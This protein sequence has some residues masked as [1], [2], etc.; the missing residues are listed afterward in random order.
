M[1]DDSVIAEFQ[2]ITGCDVERA[3]FYI[4][5]ANGQLELAISSF[6]EN[7]GGADD[8]VPPEAAA[9][10]GAGPAA[11]AASPP[12]APAAAQPPPSLGAAAAAAAGRGGVINFPDDDSDESEGEEGQAFYAGGS[13]HSGNVILGPG[14]KKDIVGKL[15]KKA[16]ESG[17]EEVRPGEQGTSSGFKAFQGGGFKLGS[18]EAPSQF[19]GKP[20]G[21]AGKAAEPRS[22]VLKM[23]QEGFSLDDGDL[24]RYDDP[25]NREFLAN[26]M[27]GSIPTEL[28]RE[29]QGG[30]VHVDMEDHR[31]E[32]FVKPKRKIKPFEG[33]GQTLGSIAPQVVSA[34]SGGG[35]SADPAQAE[36]QA[37]SQAGVDESKP[38]TNIQVRLADGSR[39]IVKLNHEQTVGTLRQYICT[40]RPQYGTTPF[41]LNTTFPNKELTDDSQT[42][43]AAGLLGAAVLQRLK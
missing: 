20:G 28:I 17:A 43:K 19:V 3:K 39:L 22:F 8:D 34:P 12:A 2:A 36:T 35:A 5:S 15:F 31:N 32:E 42:L 40:A 6:Y 4:E 18:D 38:T 29:A 1:A 24:R 30:E 7:G 23:W 13:T 21:S 9:G 26:I 16:R 10:G 37:K 14:K 25:A 33:S 41:N 27:R 11:A